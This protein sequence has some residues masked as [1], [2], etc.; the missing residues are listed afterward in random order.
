MSETIGYIALN[1]INKL[2]E[3]YLPYAMVFLGILIYFY[4][5]K[6]RINNFKYSINN[7][8]FRL[9]IS[10]LSIF[11]LIYLIL[12]NLGLV[13]GSLILSSGLLSIGILYKFNKKNYENYFYLIIPSILLIISTITQ[14]ISIPIIL[15][16]FIIYFFIFYITNK[17]FYCLAVL[18]FI[19]KKFYIGPLIIG[20]AFHAAEHF[21]ATKNLPLG[22]FS[23]FPNI[24]YLEEISG[25]IVVKLLKIITFNSVNISIASARTLIW[26]A[27]EPIIFWY[28]YKRSKLLSILLILLLPVDR[29]SIIFAL[30]YSIIII[31]SYRLKK[32]N[33][34][35]GSLCFLPIFCLGISPTYFLIP[36]L[37]I[38]GLLP[39]KRI[40]YKNIIFIL[41]FWLFLLIIFKEY[42]FFYL[43]TY[44]EFSANYDIG[45]STST[46]NLQ[47]KDLI[48]WPIY[49]FTISILLADSIYN[50]S[51]I[52]INSLKYIFL[53]VI[54][55]QFTTYGYG[56]I[57]SGFSR[58]VSLGI[59]L[60]YVASQLSSRYN[61]L[62]KCI[63]IAVFLLYCNISLPGLISKDALKFSNQK[64]SPLELDDVNKKIVQNI[65]NFSNG[66]SVINYS[67]EP[68]ITPF[69]LNSLTPTF[70]SP[71]VTL[72]RKSQEKVIDFIKNN[73]NAIIYIGHSFIT[74]D[75][76][77]IRLRA[78]II[79]KYIARHYTYHNENGNI[80]AVPNSPN[81]IPYAFNLFFNGMDLKLSP[82][83]YTRFFSQKYKY[84]EVD[85]KCS[86]NNIYRYKLLGEN[87]FIYGDF[88]CGKNLV[89]EEYIWGEMKGIEKVE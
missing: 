2:P 87:N 42:F 59:P 34:F 52:Y 51:S 75:Q 56:R 5:K 85:I 63:L 60:V 23:I 41:A 26:I 21:L 47:S 18:I 76:V 15:I 50:K 17:E 33:L 4:F 46:L 19:T 39:L 1:S 61:L 35:I 71:F 31:N 20:D 80:Y 89:P 36:A 68:A 7:D 29:L 9:I 58:L 64:N 82:I 72:G 10:Y 54:L 28:S 57:D 22:L 43:G 16:I 13:G 11:S 78:P 55:Y 8:Y 86:D 14:T 48:F 40:N 3:Y 67:M 77:D 69:I 24:G 81:D 62:S 53:I 37:S 88:S 38:L 30:I 27:L 65:N 25:V 83:F 66:R 44:A 79:F 12:S 49:V 70:T 6:N 32:N 84:L 73:P 74:F 45:L